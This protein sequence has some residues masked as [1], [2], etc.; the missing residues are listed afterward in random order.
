[1]LRQ[2]KPHVGRLGPI[3]GD[4]Q[5]YQQQYEDPNAMGQPMDGGMGDMDAGL[6]GG[7]M[8]MDGEMME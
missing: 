5:M 8:G 3:D 2:Q 6:V 4:G 1:M 7:D